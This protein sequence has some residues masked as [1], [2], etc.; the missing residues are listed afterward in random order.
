MIKTYSGIL[1]MNPKEFIAAHKREYLQTKWE[2]FDYFKNNQGCLFSD[3]F[4]L[5]DKL[6]STNNK[7]DYI[8]SIDKI[9]YFKKRKTVYQ[10]IVEDFESNLNNE[11]NEQLKFYNNI[12]SYIEK[13]NESNKELFLF[14]RLIY[15]NINAHLEWRDY[16]ADFCDNN[17]ELFRHYVN[18]YFGARYNYFYA[19]YY[20]IHNAELEIKTEIKELKLEQT[21]HQDNL[22]FTTEFIKMEPLFLDEFANLI[23]T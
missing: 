13:W 6:K 15:Q 18:D 23:S 10:N 16:V 20:S 21:R 17:S 5:E 12:Y 3:R 22:K 19:K 4:H 11:E 9:E 7:L 14:K 8:K 1:E 2:Q